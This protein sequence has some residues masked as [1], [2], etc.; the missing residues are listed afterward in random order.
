MVF[1]VTKVKHV[2]LKILIPEHT[3]SFLIFKAT[4][5]CHFDECNEFYNIL[6]GSRW[7]LKIFRIFENV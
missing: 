6:R 2:N 3:V 1:E 5:K 4:L 7:C